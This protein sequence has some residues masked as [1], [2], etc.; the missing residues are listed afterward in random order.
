MKYKHKLLHNTQLLQAGLLLI[1]FPLHVLAQVIPGAGSLLQEIQPLRPPAPSSTG[2]GLSVEPHDDARLPPSDPFLVTHILI[3]GN[4]RFDTAILHALVADA[5]GQSITLSRLGELAARLTDYYHTHGYPLARAV[6]PPQTITAGTVRI[7]ILEARYGKITLDNQSRV[8]DSLLQATLAPLQGGQPVGEAELDHV[9]LLLSDIPGAAT[10]A[11]LKAGE[12][13]GTSDLLVGAARV[14]V[15]SG[16][17]AL[18]NEGNRYTGRARIGGT[19]NVIDPLHHGDVLGASVLSSGSG[20]NYGRVSYDT[21][22]NGQGTH[23]GAS[24]SALHYVLGDTL[25]AL[26]A[27]GTA[28]VASLW[29]RQPLLRSRDVNLYGQIQYDGLQLRDHVDASALKTD[30][31]LNNWTASLSGDARDS[32]LT[33]GANAWSVGWSAGRISFDDDAAQLADAGSARTQGHFSKWNANLVRLQNLRPRDSLYL[34]VSGQ[35]A[36]T[37]LDASQKMSLGGPYSVRAYDTGALSGDAGYL[38]TVEWR[39]ELGALWQGQWQTITFFDSGH[40]T[41]NHS[42]W[43]KGSNTATLSGAGLGLSWAGFDRWSARSWIAVRTG[44]LPALVAATST[45]RLWVELSRGF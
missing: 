37:N 11:I 17:A 9:L 30:R 35:W 8:M 14:P 34:S 22:L 15:V 19:I 29:V 2:T 44:P 6:I 18:D 25:A 3:S 24:W 36:N 1:F 40:V 21:L 13:I 41:G 45:V 10:T 4:T 16:S 39:H 27:H 33:G 5:E 20:M 32:W 7:D 31:H 43:A 12:Q 23:I 42:A 26:D 38:G 28:Q